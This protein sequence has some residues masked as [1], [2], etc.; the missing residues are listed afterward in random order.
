MLLME[1]PAFTANRFPGAIRKSPTTNF[2]NPTKNFPANVTARSPPIS[3][4]S[5]N[6]ANTYEAQPN[7]TDSGSASAPEVIDIHVHNP[8]N[9]NSVTTRPMQ[10]S[11]L[12]R[13]VF[14]ET[15]L[16]T[17]KSGL[18]LPAIHIVTDPIHFNM[19]ANWL[20]TGQIINQAGG[21]PNL[22]TLAMLIFLADELE[23]WQLVAQLVYMMRT[24][25]YAMDGS[26]LPSFLDIY[27]NTKNG[28]VF[29]RYTAE[30][31]IEESALGRSVSHALEDLP[32]G[33]LVD[34]IKIQNEKHAQ[35]AAQWKKQSVD[36]QQKALTEMKKHYDDC[37]QKTLAGVTVRYEEQYKKA[38]EELK[39]QC[40]KTYETALKEM[41]KRNDELQ[42]EVVA[43][44]SVPEDKVKS[45]EVE[46]VKKM[47]LETI[48]EIKR[49]NDD[50]Y[51]K[52]VQD[53]QRLNASHMEAVKGMRSVHE[54]R[55]AEL[56]REI[57]NLKN[58]LALRGVHENTEQSGSGETDLERAEEDPGKLYRAR[59]ELN[60]L[61]KVVEESRA[62]IMELQKINTEAKQRHVKEV[63]DLQTCLTGEE[64]RYQKDLAEAMRINEELTLFKTLS[65]NESND[66]KQALEENRSQISS[67]KEAHSELESQSQAEI[68]ELR[69]INADAEE[70]T[71]REIAHLTKVHDDTEARHQDELAAKQMM[72]DANEDRN[73]RRVMDLKKVNEENKE[74]HKR[75]M[76][77]LKK[78][79]DRNEEYRR[80]EVTEL[81][82]V[83]R[84]LVE[85]NAKL[86]SDDKEKRALQRETVSKR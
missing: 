72:M 67:L 59:H 2:S 24:R 82:R 49:M 13:S 55:E 54:E 53:T 25:Q 33:M 46:A 77:E 23:L 56:Q 7:P 6:V 41:K 20:H 66:L 57:V 84:D 73:R 29:R 10:R 3:A 64:E 78:W 63:A 43:K 9:Y 65:Q 47:N 18:D 19:V 36:S 62:Q 79:K 1:I 26:I 48:T 52:L 17:L 45:N 51:N 8:T 14:F 86:R 76:A 44:A 74:R 16:A 28:N 70:R 58:T 37:H 12:L 83:N 35:Y 38:K 40:N 71:R 32:T 42:Q 15:R 81:N 31:Y 60:D 34:I 68:A 4:A 22:H 85:D 61:K 11:V 50:R 39:V 27:K 69:R 30:C 80:K 5:Y 21:V 75:E